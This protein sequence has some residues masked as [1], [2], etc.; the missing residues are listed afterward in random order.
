[1]RSFPGALA[2]ALLLACGGLAFAQPPAGQT[3]PAQAPLFR[4]GTQVVALYAT[5]TDK[6]GRLVPNLEKSDFQVYDD[7]KLQP[8]TVFRNEVEPFTVVVLLDTSASMTGSLDLLQAA[9]EQFLL[10]MLPADKGMVGAFNDKIQLSGEFTSS[11][12][13]LISY[14]H[15]LDYGN[16]TRLYDAIAAG[17]D[18]LQSVSGRRVI[19]VFTD[20]DDT[21]SHTSFGTVLDRARAEGV[22]VYAIGLRSRYFDGVRMVDSRP[23]SRLRKLAE[24]TGGGYFE[25]RKRNDLGSTF[26]RV[27]E[28]LHAQYVLGF[29]PTVLDGKIH[30][31]TVRITRPGMTARAKKSYVATAQSLAPSGR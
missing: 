9:A 7:G 20:G 29:A 27:A 19:L 23:D 5:V 26:T 13:T 11:R 15:Q 18:E 6:E 8:L 14:L 30:K 2:F 10:R 12:G 21:D 25:L 3:P 28:E 22:M 24:E 17:L 1:M 16:P 31:L 4:S